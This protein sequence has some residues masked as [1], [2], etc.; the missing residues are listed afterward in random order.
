MRRKDL[1]TPVRRCGQ[2]D[3]MPR[4]PLPRG[5]ARALAQSLAAAVT[6][7]EHLAAASP[8]LGRLA[9]PWMAH[10]LSH[11]W[12]LNPIDQ[13]NPNRLNLII[14]HI[15]LDCT[16]LC[17]WRSHTVSDFFSTNILISPLNCSTELS[18][19][20]FKNNSIFKSCEAAMFHL[21][22]LMRA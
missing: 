15:Q 13:S 18:P 3:V 19:C 14:R 7:D 2:F 9:S 16:L 10:G 20:T 17:G 21:M 8:A 5:V 6:I 4:D 11:P 12:R 1:E 22:F